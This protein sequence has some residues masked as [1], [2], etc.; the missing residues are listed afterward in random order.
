MRKAIFPILIIS[1]A[2]CFLAVAGK[3]APLPQQNDSQ[4]APPPGERPQFNRRGDMAAHDRSGYGA[5]S[6]FARLRE[7][8]RHQRK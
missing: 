4:A 8:H 5:F 3:A 7:N 1:L 6:G 2:V